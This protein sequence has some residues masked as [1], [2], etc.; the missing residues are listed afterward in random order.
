MLY[1][2]IK[3]ALGK[4]FGSLRRQKIA[5]EKEQVKAAEAEVLTPLD[6][7]EARRK[8]LLARDG[9]HFRSD[10]LGKVEFGS[11][12]R[13][14][15][16][17]ERR[18]NAELITAWLADERGLA[19]SIWDPELTKE[20]GSSVYRL[21]LMVLKFVTISL[22]PTVDVKMVTLSE[23]D[24]NL[25]VFVLQSVDFDPNIQILPGV[26]VSASA[27]GIQIEVAGELRPSQDGTG[28]AGTISFQTAG[29]LPR[30]MR[31][32]PEAVLKAASNRINNTI[33]N[34]AIQ[35]FERGGTANYHEF[36]RAKMAASDS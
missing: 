26:G 31:L 5:P 33:A 13:V 16:T 19:M 32:L 7:A 6:A 25:P 3:A 22:A 4:P 29:K 36:R 11:T 23:G 27:L 21:Q 18:P 34:F 15:A 30:P 20:L 24:G 14:V 8:V 10:R 2:R 12:A 28:V 17:L 9:P 35:S 1:D